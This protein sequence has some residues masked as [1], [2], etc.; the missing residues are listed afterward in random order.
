MNI[1]GTWKAFYSPVGVEESEDF[2]PD[3]SATLTLKN[4]TIDGSDPYGG[5]YKGV[6][7]LES[8]RFIAQIEI[9]T[10]DTEAVTIYES[11]GIGFPV[12]VNIDTEYSSPGHIVIKGDL[13]GSLPIIGQAERIADLTG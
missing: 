1:D 7:R 10:E 13:N 12:V 5:N 11:L 8:G 2:D 9:T 6:F 3:R 4:G